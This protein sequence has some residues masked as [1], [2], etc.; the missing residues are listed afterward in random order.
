MTKILP[1]LL[2]SNALQPNPVRLMNQGSFKE[3]VEHGLDLLRNNKISGGEKV[4]VE[5]CI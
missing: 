5:I 2:A 3:R 1:Q 4:V